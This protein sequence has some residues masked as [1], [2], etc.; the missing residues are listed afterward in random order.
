M[1]DFFR[2]LFGTLRFRGE[3]L[4]VRS[5]STSELSLSGAS[6]FFLLLLVVLLGDAAEDF[7]FALLPIEA[8]VGLLATLSL[9]A[10]DFLDVLFGDDKPDLL[11]FFFTTFEISSEPDFFVFSISVEALAL[12]VFDLLATLSEVEDLALVAM[13]PLVLFDSSS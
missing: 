4:E 5:A 9:M 8:V 12:D 3:E 11:V 2:L 1:L 10:F 6:P 7:F 13:L